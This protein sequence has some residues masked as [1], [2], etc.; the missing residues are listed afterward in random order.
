M[1]GLFPLD[2]LPLWL[3]RVGL[4]TPIYYGAQALMDIMIRGKGWSAIS[5]D[6]YVLVGFS[7]LFMILNVLA[8]RKHRRM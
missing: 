6:A 4:A 1:S 5:L 7:L 8:L 2:T 3:Q